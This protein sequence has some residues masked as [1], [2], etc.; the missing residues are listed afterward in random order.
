MLVIAFEF[1]EVGDLL[2]T[3]GGGGRGLVS[4]VWKENRLTSRLGTADSVVKGEG[5]DY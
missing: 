3:G 1:G 2:W 4:R 5:T